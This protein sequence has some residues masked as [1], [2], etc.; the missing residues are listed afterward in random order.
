MSGSSRS[1]LRQQPQLRAFIRAVLPGPGPRDDVMQE[2]SLALWRAFDR[3]DPARPFGP[4]ARSRDHKIVLKS[5]AD[6]GRRAPVPISGRRCSR[7]RARRVWTGRSP[8]RETPRISVTASICCLSGRVILSA[9]ATKRPWACLPSPR[10]P[11]CRWRRRT[12][13]SSGSA[14]PC[15]SASSVARWPSTSGVMIG[16]VESG[17]P[18]RAALLDGVATAGEESEL[19]ALLV[20]D[21]GVARLFVER[22]SFEAQLETALREIAPEPIRG[23]AGLGR[24]VH[25]RQPRDGRRAGWPRGAV[26]RAPRLAF[27]AICRG[28]EFPRRFAR[29]LGGRCEGFA[30]SGWGRSRR[31]TLLRGSGPILKSPTAPATISGV[32]RGDRDGGGGGH[33]FRGATGSEGR[34][35]LGR[36]RPR[37][38]DSA[39]ARRVSRRGDVGTLLVGCADDSCTPG[40]SGDTVRGCSNRQRRFAAQRSDF[41]ASDPASSLRVG[42]GCRAQGLRRGVSGP[43][44]CRDRNRA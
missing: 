33:V 23:P 9:F 11:N 42:T 14:S 2:V 19:D 31:L 26:R 6:L 30:S 5:S 44:A 27:A 16:A 18:H 35:G 36:T 17:D 29:V 37:P 32:L 4:W 15:A 39:R 12:R 7:L 40:R 25:G 1:S 22:A 10:T 20:A 41:A 28:R 43:V 3:Y 8:N 24:P 38:C 13:P 34:G 21:S